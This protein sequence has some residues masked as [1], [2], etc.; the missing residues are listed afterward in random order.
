MKSQTKLSFSSRVVVVEVVV[1]L[2]NAP[3]TVTTVAVKVV[4]VVVVVADISHAHALSLQRTRR[5][6]FQE[7]I[8]NLSVKHSYNSRSL[9]TSDHRCLLRDFYTEAVLRCLDVNAIGCV[10]GVKPL[11]RSALAAALRE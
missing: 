7:S 1:L 2:I 10:F 11:E 9:F 4:V 6:S 3:T 5:K 8:L